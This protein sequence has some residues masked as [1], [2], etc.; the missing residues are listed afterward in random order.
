MSNFLQKPGIEKN[1]GDRLSYTEINA[2]DNAIDSIIDVINKDLMSV[3]NI[4][5]EFTGD[6]P[7][8]SK[9]FT[10]S[11]AIGL[12]SKQR[13]SPKMIIKFL[14]ITT[15]SWVEYQYGG[16]N[17]DDKFWNNTDYWKQLESFQIIDGGTF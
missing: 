16:T 12:V 13:R 1:Q 6:I 2:L 3:C 8:M 4:N 15:N 14:D 17:L 7:D 5:T 11:E 10:V 9:K